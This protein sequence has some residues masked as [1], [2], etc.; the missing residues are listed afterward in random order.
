[1]KFDAKGRELPDPTPME[2]PAGFQRPA[3]LQEQ[4]ERC[5]RQVVSRN[6]EAR[7]KESFEEANDFETDDPDPTELDTRYTLMG[8]ETPHGHGRDASNQDPPR[9]VPAGTRAAERPPAGTGRTGEHSGES[10]EPEE[11]SDSDDSDGPDEGTERRGG[12]PRERTPVR[13]NAPRTVRNPAP[14]GGRTGAGAARQPVK[15]KPR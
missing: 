10:E 15:R 13:G 12:Q 8:E 4:I 11:G 3:T 14:Q 9:G 7:G 1:M 5:F 6:A 2:I